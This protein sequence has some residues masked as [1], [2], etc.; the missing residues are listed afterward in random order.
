[1][2]IDG[3]PLLKKKLKSLPAGPGVY[4][5]LDE[6]GKI[7]YVGKAKNLRHRVTSYTQPERMGR[8]IRKMVFE[9]RD[10]VVVETTTEAEALLLEANL[11]KS[12]K[13]KYNVTFRD[14]TS[15]ISILITDEE[16]PQ[17]RSYRGS[18]KEKGQYFGPYPSAEAVHK[19][20]DVMERIF[21]LRT[22]SPGIF[23]H[24]TRPCLKY[25]IKRCS[26]PCVGRIGPQEY[27][28]RLQE[29]TLFLQGK[30]TQVQKRVHKRMAA[31]AAAQDYETAAVE[32]DRLRFLTEVS[33]NRT[34]LTHAL[35][36]ADVFALVMQGGRACVQGFFYRNGQHAGN[37]SYTPK[38]MADMPPPEVLR[39][40]LAQYYAAHPPPPA[41]YTNIVPV[42]Q[43]VLAEA[44]S[45]TA[46][47]KV[48]LET[49]QRGAKATLVEQAARNAQATLNRQ[50]A[51]GEGW[52]T[53]M[54]AFGEMLGL[55]TPPA[56]VEC[57]D[58]SNISGK[59]PV[60]SLVVAGTEGM[61]KK[62]YRRFKVTSKNTPDD[63]AMMQEVLLRRYQRLLK[64][65]T[66]LP[67]IIMVDGGKGHL[68]IL[69]TVMKNLDILD[70]PAC[71]A[72][73]AIAKGEERNKGLE[74]IFHWQ[75]RIVQLA[76]P[77]HAPLIFLLQKVRDEAH[78]FAIGFHRQQRGKALTSS[79]LENIP[80]IGPKRKKALLLHFGSLAS[81]KSAS[82]E[83]L[84]KVE[85]VSKGRA[86]DIHAFFH[87]T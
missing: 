77:H 71:P 64:D 60:A 20:L 1:M 51:E 2:A 67:D 3:L 37:Q 23:R 83:E 15:Y 21:G 73:V 18:R 48:K 59:Q 55:T 79:V 16:T 27:A 52:R 70:D 66:A 38:I 19:T 72:L 6:A 86:G 26:A 41:I 8:R 4:R 32:R 46:G 82:I 43:A 80:G 42:D 7:L 30:G 81:I 62:A 57:F 53:Q 28:Q 13:P 12:L 33:S 74:Q 24:R 40:F 22:C 54:A 14:D 31:A 63:Y 75:K 5:M 11:I 17:I 69:V 10:L 58:I 76:V 56:R 36:E 78:R 9:T 29:A 87:P 85:G 44:L 47:R 61:D 35:A 25:D 68:N 49:P 34:G 50:A 39:L 45:V 65:H 84:A